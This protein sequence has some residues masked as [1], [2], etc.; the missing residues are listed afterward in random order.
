VVSLRWTRSM[1]GALGAAAVLTVVTGAPM[2]AAVAAPPPPPG[3]ASDAL[4]QYQDM[5]HQ[6][7]V[8]NGQ[9]VQADEDLKARNADLARAQKTVTQMQA[10]EEQF[11]GQVDR[12]TRASYEGASWSKAT[13]LMSSPSPIDFLD[14]A[15]ALSAVSRDNA[16]A[17]HGLADATAKAE[18][19]AKQIQQARDDAVRLANDLHA[20]QAQLKQAAD[21]LHQQYQQLSSKDQATLKSGTHVGPLGG[22]GAA[23]TA[24]NAALSKQ[25]SPYVWG[26]TGPNSFDCSGLTQWAYKQAGISLPRT[27]S[28]QVDE[29]TSVSQS[30]LKPGDLIF[31]YSDNSH[32][33]MYV[34]G[35]QVVHAPTEGEDVK[36]APYKYIGDVSAIRRVAG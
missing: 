31:F 5:G 17:V 4:K 11:R 32:V 12:F 2:P 3:N 21:Q 30:D 22:A 6:A 24:L 34:G 1:R 19:A 28:A 7:E 25:G 27:T 13:A 16:N 20:K 33:G 14:R 18:T 8:I 36:V 35:G 10:Q 9:A 26:A 15:S 23:I 29:G